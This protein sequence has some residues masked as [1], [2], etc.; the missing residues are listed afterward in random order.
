MWMREWS[1][2]ALKMC[3]HWER[4]RMKLAYVFRKF[5]DEHPQTNE[6]VLSVQLSVWNKS[7]LNNTCR[8][9]IFSLQVEYKPCEPSNKSFCWLMLS[10]ETRQECGQY[11]VISKVVLQCCNIKLQNFILS[12][13]FIINSTIWHLGA[14]VLWIWNVE[15][16]S[17]KISWTHK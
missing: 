11:A 6:K 1:Q 15:G 2:T 10:G 13:F 3:P 12:I 14:V 5:S 8:H 4:I 7:F 17:N 16:L 9:Y